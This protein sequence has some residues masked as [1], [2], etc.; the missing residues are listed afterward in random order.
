MQ[1][2]F[3]VQRELTPQTVVS[4][5]YVGSGNRRGRLMWFYNTA[6][7]PGP[8]PVLGRGLYPYI[9]PSFYQRSW[10]RSN[11][12]AFQFQLNRKFHKGLAYAVNYTYSKS[13]DF[14]CSGYENPEGCNVQDPYHPLN[15]RSVSAFDLTHIFT[16]DW[17][18]AVPIGKGKLLSTGNNKVDYA[19]GNW[20]LIGILR[21]NSGVPYN[22]T[23]P[24][25]IAN[26]G[27]VSYERPNLV[28][29]PN[30]PNPS[31]NAWFNKAAF[32]I[33]NLFTFGNF[34][35]NVL[36]NDWGR[37]LDLSMFREFPIS[38]SKKFQFRFEAFNFPNNVMLA[39]PDTNPSSPNFGRTFSQGNSPRVI[40]LA[41]KFL[42]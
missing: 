3:G 34:G 33:P 19:V 31:S 28:G 9:I 8:G 4:V 38:E 22:I 6:L 18:W 2:N 37:N 39:T 5:S 21:M 25:D 14:G 13:I 27:N 36:R 1:Y 24:G 10:E 42:F 16:A 26:T 30:L 40:Q 29:N 23:V 11:Y 12:N 17:V 20:Q 7:K 35:R 15:D 41:L 32:E